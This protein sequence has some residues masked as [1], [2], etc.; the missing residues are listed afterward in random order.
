[1]ETDKSK[2]ITELIQYTL[3]ILLLY[4]PTWSTSLRESSSLPTNSVTLSTRCWKQKKTK[5]KQAV[6]KHKTASLKEAIERHK[7][8]S[9]M[10]VVITV[11]SWF[12]W[13]TPPSFWLSMWT[14]TPNT[15]FSLSK[16]TVSCLGLPLGSSLDSQKVSVEPS[17]R[18]LLM[19]ALE[20][21][22]SFPLMGSSSI[23][24][25]STSCK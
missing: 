3:Y 12:Y 15:S 14:D 5:Q 10:A 19:A 25:T 24:I 21:G 23:R 17:V 7:Y 18:L 20:E 11:V 1:M 6:I 4:F 22:V 9:C 2:L 8:I 13:L 16:V